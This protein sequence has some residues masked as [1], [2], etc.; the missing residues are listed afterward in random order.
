[1]ALSLYLSI[2]SLTANRLNSPIERHRVAECT[3]NK[4]RLYAASKRL[5]LSILRQKVKSCKKNIQCKRKSSG[6]STYTRKT[7]FKT[8][9]AIRNKKDDCYK[10]KW[11]ISQEDATFVNICLPSI[12]VPEYIKHSNKF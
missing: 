6:S 12:I 8:N 3:K 2:I 4:I 7:D 10:N 5:I 11:S 9:M 1:M